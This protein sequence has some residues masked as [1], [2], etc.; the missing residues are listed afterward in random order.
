VLAFAL[1]VGINA[2]YFDAP[3]SS[4]FALCPLLLLL[5]QDNGLLSAFSD[6]QRYF[7]LVAASVPPRA[8]RRPAPMRRP[9]NGAPARPRA[10]RARR[11]QIGYLILSSVFTLLL[12][13]PLE[14]PPPPIPARSPCNRSAQ[15]PPALKRGH[16]R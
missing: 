12:R 2:V 13:A 8:P 1:A 3:H 7:P 11:G 5:S 16:V 15:P 14:A 4:V 6:Q 10:E 9:R